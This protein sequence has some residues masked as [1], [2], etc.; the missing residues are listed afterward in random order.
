MLL[1]LTFG[2]ANAQVTPVL[3][4]S[5]IN[6]FPDGRQVTNATVPADAIPIVPCQWVP[7]F[8]RV[9]MGAPG[10]VWH[11]EI[12]S[13]HFCDP[14]GSWSEYYYPPGESPV[15][16]V[17]LGDKLLDWEFDPG[18]LPCNDIVDCT[19][20]PW[21]QVHVSQGSYCQYFGIQADITLSGQTTPI[22]SNILCFHVVPEPASV[23][24]LGTGLL[25]LAGLARR[26]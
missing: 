15:I 20:F 10:S 19:W 8:A 9:S 25:G 23:V 5:V 26:R 3:E 12:V 2:Q 7:I 1:A 22:W 24:L 6:G 16:E 14:E 13:M 11:I 18:A 4:I 21:G 17:E